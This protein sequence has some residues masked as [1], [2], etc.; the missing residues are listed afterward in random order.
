MAVG[1]VASFGYVGLIIGAVKG[2]SMGIL[3]GSI[4][5][6]GSA[7]NK[8]IIIWKHFSPV[9]KDGFNSMGEFFGDL[10][11]LGNELGNLGGVAA[12]AAKQGIGAMGGLSNL[13]GLTS[14][15]GGFGDVISGILGSWISLFQQLLS[16]GIDLF[17]GVSVFTLK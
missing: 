7:L 10:G 9:A 8:K 12:N 14:M 3:K 11:T 1:S 2:L 13:G 5:A 4:G 16:G 17:S 15:F 6:F